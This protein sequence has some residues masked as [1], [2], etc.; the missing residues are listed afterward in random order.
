ML[1]SRKAKKDPRIEEIERNMAM[2][3]DDHEQRIRELN[4]AI[5]EN[6]KMIEENRKMIEELKKKIA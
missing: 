3:L 2:I 1:F 6:Q 5:F 4:E